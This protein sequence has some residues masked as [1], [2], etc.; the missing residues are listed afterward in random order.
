V[1]WLLLL[2]LAACGGPILKPE[3]LVPPRYTR[4]DQ[5]LED[6]GEPCVLEGPEGGL[7][8][9]HY[10][11]GV[12]PPTTTEEVCV[13]ECSPGCAQEWTFHVVG[14]IIVNSAGPPR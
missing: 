14:G 2:A 7:Q 13:V 10:C 12:C 6:F 3:D 1:R 9:W 4:T 5:L 11:A 8:V